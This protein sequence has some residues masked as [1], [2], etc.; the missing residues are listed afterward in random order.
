MVYNSIQNFKLFTPEYKRK[1][2]SS[3][4][5]ERYPDKRPI[6]IIKGSIETPDIDRFKYI[7][8]SD[9][10][11]AEFMISIRKHIKLLKHQTIFLLVNNTIL[12]QSDIIK[13]IY[14]S[15]KDP[16]GLLYITYIVESTFG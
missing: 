7:V 2:D 8:H 14:N 16:D 15:Q 3:K 10:T 11:I 5:L 1:I 9:M 13:T 12:K 6:I 4:L